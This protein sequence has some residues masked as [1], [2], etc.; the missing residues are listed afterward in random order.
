[1]FSGSPKLSP[2]KNPTFSPVGDQNS[3]FLDFSFILQLYTGQMSA[4]MEK[5]HINKNI[6]NIYIKIGVLDPFTNI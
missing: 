6:Q 5:I 2:S 4:T 3:R 1:M